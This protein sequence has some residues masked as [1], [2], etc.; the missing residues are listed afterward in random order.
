VAAFQAAGQVVLLT[1]D[2]ENCRTMGTQLQLNG[3]NVY[4][5]YASD[6]LKNNRMVASISF[7][8]ELAQRNDGMC[9]LICSVLDDDL[10]TRLLSNVLY[11]SK[12]LAKILFDLFLILMSDQAFKMVIAVAYTRAYAP[13]ARLYARGLGISSYNVYGLSVQFLNREIFVNEVCYAHSF[14]KGCVAA[15]NSMMKTAK[16]LTQQEAV[17][18]TDLAVDMTRALRHNLVQKR[19]YNPIIGDLN[20]LEYFCFFFNVPTLLPKLT[21][22][23]LSLLVFVVVAAVAIVAFVVVAV[24]SPPVCRWCSPFPA[25]PG[26][27]SRSAWTTG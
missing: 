1:A 17:A 13:I 16:T 2:F 14:L 27:S 11:L 23:V 5:G 22:T 24:V 8:Y 20:V 26:C 3:Y 18:S 12:D 15:L 19:R 21:L 9:R 6:K 4:V 25:W 10:L 7:L